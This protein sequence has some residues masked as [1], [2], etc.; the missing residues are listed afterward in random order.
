MHRTNRAP[1]TAFWGLLLG[2]ALGGFCGNQAHTQQPPPEGGAAPP[3]AAAPV[4]PPQPL[5]G[6]PAITAVPALLDPAR[7]VPSVIVPINGTLKIQMSTKERIATV[8]NQ[9]D[10]VAR[11]SPVLGDPTSVLITGFEPGI[12]R[13]L[14]TGVSGRQEVIDVVVQIDVEYLRVLLRRAA[15][16]AFI[17]PIPAANNTVILTGTVANAEDIDIILKTAQSVVLGPDRVINA[18]R[19]GGVQQVQLCVVVARVNRSKIR[20]MGF[21][22]YEAG[23]KHKVDST[24]GGTFNATAAATPVFPTEA[25]SLS[26]TPNTNIIFTILDTNKQAFLGFLQALVTEDLAKVLSEPRL[27]TLSGRPASFLD[28]GEQAVPIPAGLGQ[29]G[30]QFEE[31][32]TRLNFIP[33]VLGNGKIHLEVEPEVSILSNQGAVNIGGAAVQGRLTQRVHTTVEIEDGQT[34]MIG[35]LI[36]RLLNSQAVKIPILGDLPVVGA[37][38]RTIE[39]D[40]TETELVVLVTPHL[41]DPM[42]CDQLPKHL[43]GMETRSPDDYELFLEGILEAPRGPRDVL[44]DGHFVPAYKNGP[45]AGTYPC[46]GGRCGSGACGGEGCNGGCGEGCA[47]AAGTGVMSAGDHG[48]STAAV[49][50][51]AAAP[52]TAPAA[53]A[54]TPAAGDTTADAATKPAPAALPPADGGG[55]RDK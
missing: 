45:T 29:I 37:A 51:P 3:A 42:A 4:P 9:K 31:F 20:N 32:G 25:N 17:D 22:F 48:P 8:Q 19:V 2:L 16:T 46:A 28:G 40:E 24:F 43:P 23:T 12:T 55:D 49:A 1:R 30:V 14:F 11:V 52:A 41:V 13:I 33:V 34:L 50:A 10:T 6:Q 53:G 18:L 15:P 5:P 38:F 26:S 35:G 47:P 27:V 39:Q 36:Q 7:P 21:T 54:T 44:Q